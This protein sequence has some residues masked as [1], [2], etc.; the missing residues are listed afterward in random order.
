MAAFRLRF[1][2]WVSRP[3]LSHVE[4]PFFDVF[5]AANRVR[6]IHVLITP[7]DI[8]A[9][10]QDVEGSQQNHRVRQ[11]VICYGIK[12]IQHGLL[13]GLFSAEKQIFRLYGY[14]SRTR[15]AITKFEK[16]ETCFAQL[17]ARRTR[18]LVARAASDSSPRHRGPFATRVPCRIRIICAAIFYIQKY[19]Q[20]KA[21]LVSFFEGCA[22]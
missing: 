7:S 14:C 9:L 15:R 10:E 8:R 2:E 16:G 18:L 4:G 1:V 12:R 11:A 5:V 17:L 19:A 6:C 20:R 13:E 22:I 21:A 3:E